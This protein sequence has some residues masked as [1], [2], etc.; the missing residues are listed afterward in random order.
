MAGQKFD[1]TDLGPVWPK[2][3]HTWPTS[4]ALGRSRRTTVRNRFKLG[5]CWSKSRNFRQASVQIWCA[6]RRTCIQPSVLEDTCATWCRNSW[7]FGTLL[8]D[9][10]SSLAGHQLGRQCC[11]RSRTQATQIPEMQTEF[12]MVSSINQYRTTLMQ[13]RPSSAKSRGADS[14]A[15]PNDGPA[16][17]PEPTPAGASRLTR[18]CTGAR[19]AAT[20]AATFSLTTP[21]TRR[22]SPSVATTST[23][24]DAKAMA[25]RPQPQPSS[26]AEPPGGTSA[27]RPR[28]H[29][30]R[31]NTSARRHPPRGGGTTLCA[32]WGV[33]SMEDPVELGKHLPKF[34]TISAHIGQVGPDL[35]KLGPISTGL[36]ASSTDFDAAWPGIDQT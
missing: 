35:A 22:G 14:A 25:Q 20:F 10:P 19:R 28:R 4:A 30:T 15:L 2:P 18:A 36:E 1:Q 3:A 6:P 7:R 17:A 26:R 23:P 31:A 8:G 13:I 24:K 5:Q 27:S 12:G 33:D 34:E 16:R 21:S 9:A 29:K 32:C 11:Q